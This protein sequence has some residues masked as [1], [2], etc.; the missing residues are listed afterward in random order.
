V[1]RIEHYDVGDL[2]TPL[3]TW[4]VD[5]DAD[6]VPDADTDP[7][8]II[9]RLKTPAGV[10]SVVTTASSPSSLTAASTPLARISQGVFQMNPGISLDAPGY[11]F[12][13][14]E[15]VG[16]AEASAAFQAVVDPSEFTADAGLS[17]RALVGLAETKDWLQRSNIELTLAYDATIEGWSRALELRDQETEG[18]TQRV[19]D[20]TIKM[21]GAL[22]ISDEE[23]VHIRRGVLLHDIGKMGIPDSILLKPGPLTEDEWVIMRKHP[24][25]AYELLSPIPYLNASIDIPYCHHER[26]DGTGYPRG[27]SKDQIPLASR[28]FSIIDNWDALMNDRPYRAAW[29]ADRVIKFLS[30]EAGRR[31]DPE[32]VE[33]FL[34]RIHEETE[35]AA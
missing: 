10:E 21:A 15:G 22:G 35:E 11:W 19:T 29:P 6:G 12:L 30:D 18:H 14:A 3:M 26:W 31:F 13:R 2:W 16:A 20:L 25:Y 28:L 34:A 1:A 24:Q 4:K 9:I 5:S 7:S 23:I 32:L 33:F 17:S 27:L 8:Q